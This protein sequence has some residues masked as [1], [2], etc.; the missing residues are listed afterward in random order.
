MD[1]K[2]D[3]SWIYRNSV[4]FQKEIKDEKKEFWNTTK[5]SANH[6]RALRVE[7]E[8]LIINSIFNLL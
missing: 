3:F 1:I 2:V 7:R 4:R 5:Q 8:L 6:A